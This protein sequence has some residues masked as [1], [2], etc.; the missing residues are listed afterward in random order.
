[1]II[2]KHGKTYGE[3][4]CLNCGAVIGYAERD[5]EHKT[6]HDA[7]NGNLHETSST[8]IYCPECGCRLVLSLKIDGEVRTTE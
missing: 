8:F 4:D 7:Y 1:M 2:L 6:M 3:K 5:V